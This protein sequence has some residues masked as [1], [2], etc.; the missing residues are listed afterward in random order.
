MLP[1]IVFLDSKAEARSGDF[2]DLKGLATTPAASRAV[3]RQLELSGGIPRKKA[4]HYQVSHSLT[5]DA[6][7]LHSVTSDAEKKNP[8]LHGKRL[9]V[10]C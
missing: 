8:F 2:C 9:E 1:I 6:R 5:S 10:R 4:P 3:I 7:P